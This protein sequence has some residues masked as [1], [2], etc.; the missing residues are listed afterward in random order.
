MKNNKL[1]KSCGKAPINVSLYELIGGSIRSRSNI[2]RLIENIDWDNNYLLDFSNVQFMSRAFSDELYNFLK[3]HANVVIN[4]ETM[5][6][7]VRSSREGKRKRSE[8]SEGDIIVLNTVE[9]VSD[10][11]SSF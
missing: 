9:E 11:F 8:S 1:E 3:R 2:K 10:Y 4:E 5:S 6:K 7:A